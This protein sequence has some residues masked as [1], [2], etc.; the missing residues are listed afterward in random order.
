MT[1]LLSDLLRLT[2]WAA[3]IG[4][5]VWWIWSIRRSSRPPARTPREDA[6]LAGLRAAIDR[7][8]SREASRQ[9]A[10]PQRT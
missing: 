8:R 2:Y 4:A 10:Q 1:E 9:A 6:E 3:I 5:V 7:D